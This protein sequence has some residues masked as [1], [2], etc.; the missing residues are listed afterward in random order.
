MLAMAND[1]AAPIDAELRDVL[2]GT[3]RDIYDAR[4]DSA[5]AREATERQLA[6]LDAAARNAPDPLSAS[7]YNSGRSAALVEL[8]R[9]EEAIAILQQSEKDLPGE[10]DPPYRFAQLYE[11]LKRYDDA[12]AEA[13]KA[14]AHAP[15]K[16]AVQVM[17]FRANLQHEAKRDADACTTLRAVVTDEGTLPKSERLPSV[18]ERAQKLMK[19]V[20]GSS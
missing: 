8:G 16:F 14:I 9:P 6:V 11:K 5:K 1:A 12:I 2:W 13:D 17:Y 19:T 10:P 15:K 18:V 20:C 7:A 4:G 3:I